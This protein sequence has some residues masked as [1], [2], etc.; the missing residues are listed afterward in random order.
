MK[1]P[2]PQPSTKRK[3]SEITNKKAIITI[4]VASITT[5]IVISVYFIASMYK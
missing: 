1:T 4:I 3:K 5:I 2:N